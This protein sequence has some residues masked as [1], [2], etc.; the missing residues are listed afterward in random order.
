MIT[1]MFYYKIVL[2]FKTVLNVEFLLHLAL[3]SAIR[4]LQ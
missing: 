3:F 2:F 4:K 1:C